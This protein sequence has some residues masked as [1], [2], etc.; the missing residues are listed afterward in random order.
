ME[1]WLHDEVLPVAAAM[2]ADYGRAIPAED[3]FDELHAQRD[4][5]LEGRDGQ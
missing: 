1:R 2:H 3:L 4:A 5:L